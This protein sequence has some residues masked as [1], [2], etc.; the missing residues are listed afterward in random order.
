MAVKQDGRR[1]NRGTKG[2]KGGRKPKAEELKIAEKIDQAIAIPD[3]FEKVAEIAL[4]DKNRD[5]MKAIELLLAYRI[6][7]PT[8]KIENKVDLRKN[9]P[10]WMDG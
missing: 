2:N 1:N 3:I 6:G 8:Q 4:D 10:D 7:K 5:Q 9:L